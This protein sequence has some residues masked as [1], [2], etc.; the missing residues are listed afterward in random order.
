M[1]GGARA[2][3]FRASFVS[4]GVCYGPAMGILHLIVMAGVW[5][6]SFA[7]YRRYRRME[8]DLLAG[9]DVHYER[10][11][12]RRW[13]GQPA[14][15]ERVRRL[16]RTY[17]VML[18]VPLALPPLVYGAL[19]WHRSWRIQQFEDEYAAS[20]CARFPDAETFVRL[21]PEP[22]T[23]PESSGFSSDDGCSRLYSFMRVKGLDGA[24]SVSSRY[25]S[26]HLTIQKS[27]PYGVEAIVAWDP[28]A[29]SHV[30]RDH[31]GNSVFEFPGCGGYVL[32]RFE[33]KAIL[34]PDASAALDVT[35]ERI[36]QTFYEAARAQC[37]E[38]AHP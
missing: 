23:E 22:V 5:I 27:L 33:S 38:T 35:V 3:R 14:T 16:R 18:I 8:I 31:K 9:L 15:L 28:E 17:L 24:E 34:T 1:N 7:R 12:G 6:L 11:E 36:A 25:I 10:G 26:L 4:E 29:S 32:G 37:P 13:A 30:S 2:E 19:E 20:V 21:F